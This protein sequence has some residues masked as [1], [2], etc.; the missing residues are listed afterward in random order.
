MPFRFGE[1]QNKL[2]T[3]CEDVVFQEVLQVSQCGVGSDDRVW[4]CSCRTI[5]PRHARRNLVCLHVH[6]ENKSNSNSNTVCESVLHTATAAL[7]GFT[8]LAS[9]FFFRVATS[10]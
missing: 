6:N 3:D 10:M 9:H 8:S 7:T 5:K 1:Q 2:R 4:V